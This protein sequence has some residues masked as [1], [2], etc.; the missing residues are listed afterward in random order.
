MK[1]NSYFSLE[2]IGKSLSNIEIAINR[3]KSSEVFYAV[4]NVRYHIASCLNRFFLYI[5]PDR[6][7]A[8][9]AQ[10]V[11]SS[12]IGE[13]IPIIFE[14]E[15]VL[16]NSYNVPAYSLGERLKALAGLIQNKF[17]GI[18]ISAEGLQQYYPKKSIFQKSMRSVSVGDNLDLGDFINS[19][20]NIGYKREKKAEERGCFSV[21]GDT[22]N[23]Y[24]YDAEY[25]YRVE[26]FDNTVEAIKYYDDADYSI[27]ENV[28]K[29]IILPASDILLDNE[30]KRN[31]LRKLDQQKKM[32]KLKL[33]QIF[34]EIKEKFINNSSNPALTWI[35]PFITEFSSSIFDYLPLESVV[36]FDDIRSIDDKL[37]LLQNAHYIRVKGFLESGEAS[38]L[39]NNAIYSTKKIYKLMSDVTKLGFSL[40]SS[41]NPIYCPQEIFSIKSQSIPKYFNNFNQLIDDIRAYV[42]NQARVFI[43]TKKYSHDNIIKNLRSQNIAAFKYSYGE[44]EAE[45]NVIADEIPT[46]FVYSGEKIVVIGNEDIERQK[47]TVMRVRKRS[48]FIL[49]TEGDYVVHDKHG[50]GISQGMVKI[51]TSE[52]YKDFYVIMYRDGDKLYLPATQLDSLEKYSGAEN[53]TIHKLGGIEFDRVK[54]RVKASIKKMT[55]DLIKLYEKRQS[56]K[57]HQYQPDTVWQ[58]ELE[59]SFEYEETAD[60][61]IAINEIKQDME[62]GKV[63]DRLLCGDVGYGKTEVAIRAI[64]KTVLENKQA[65]ILAPTTIL[66]QQHFNTISAR[67]NPF[68]L[69]IAHLSRFVST[70]QIRHSLE[71]IKSGEINVIIG[72]HRLLSKDVVYAD[73]GLLVL[74]EEQ[75]FGVEHK[76]KIKALKGNVNVL[77]LTATPIPRTLHMSLSGIR[78]ISVLDTPPSNRIPIETY[79]TEYSDS[80]LLDAVRR[81]VARNGQVLILYNK[82]ASIE[83]FYKKMQQLF[84]DEVSMIYAHGKMQNNELEKKIRSFYEQEVQVMISTTIIE[85]GLDLPLAN[86]LIVIDADT[87]GLS[88]LYQIRGRVGRSN[89]LA[90][91]YFTV[92]K[93]KVITD[94]AAKRLEAL[95]EYT[96]FGSGMRIA[97]RDL[98]IRGAGNILGREQSGHMERVGY[99]MYCRM[100]RETVSEAVGHAVIEKKEIELDID[101]DTSLPNDYISTAQERLKFY[102]Q[103][104]T[105]SS[106]SEAKEF[107]VE[108]TKDYKAPSIGVFNIIALGVIKNLAQRLQVRR[109]AIT[110]KEVALYF[111]NDDNIQNA[112][113]IEALSNM[114]D[115]VVLS[116]TSPPSIIF[117]LKGLP[118]SQRMRKVIDFLTMANGES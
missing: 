115:Y 117:K 118:H 29:I 12:Y 89:I 113:L 108:I 75:R 9:R 8:R 36:V 66:A 48:N 96:D 2:K 3:N 19:L 81:E 7:T 11:L 63:M 50:V 110:K 103:V 57:G 109:V 30:Q 27:I 94:K 97:I 83:S 65:V 34:A 86:T 56:L 71:K 91:A 59:E 114:K 88:Q 18:I 112:Y 45:V 98:D 32:A 42:N 99:D 17:K 107:I 70:K 15:N 23:I 72:T 28:K 31:V 73:L 10:K 26:F 39:H 105:L 24:S 4:E 40:I 104:S 116:P 79:V 100:I 47:A 58:K 22:V 87:F 74:D 85:N 53:P 93:G 44:K 92:R 90:Y 78:D 51:R 1:F 16:I 80:L 101:G 46:G 62:Q 102:K 60:Q 54:K 76:D 25:P 35:M 6:L 77:S 5:V 68:K 13:N 61:I 33:S 37:T 21:H 69:K 95:M 111:Y 64:F 38:L 84:A 82:V 41:P 55:I 52:G 67:F 106:L 20:I 49:P 43:F 14:R